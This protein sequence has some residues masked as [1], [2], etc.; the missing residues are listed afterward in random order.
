MTIG[1]KIGVG[2]RTTLVITLLIG[3]LSFWRLM[4]FIISNRW[5][6]HTHLVLQDLENLLSLTKDVETGQRGYLLC[7]KS[8]FLA[9]YREG[10][11]GIKK[12]KDDLR[13]LIGDNADQIELFDRELE[14]LIAARLKFAQDVVGAGADSK[15]P[16]K[17]FAAAIEMCK[18]GTG[19][20]LMDD[21]RR[22][23]HDM[24]KI[25]RDLLKKRQADAE[26]SANVDSWLPSRQDR[27]YVA[28]LM[29]RVVEVGK[30]ANWIAPPVMGINRQPADFEYV[31]FN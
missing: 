5:V 10:L 1:K 25:E 21:I 20:K 4:D 2:V 16:A 23:V 6:A 27:A 15:E 30:Y 29:G 12:T 7:G 26:W 14:P 17:D 31:R 13:K 9:P 3:G 28:S 24:Q 8:E 18:T 11:A 19:K 22:K